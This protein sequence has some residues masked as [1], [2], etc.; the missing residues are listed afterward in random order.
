M[1]RRLA[2]AQL[3]LQARTRVSTVAGYAST[4]S[5]PPFV[6]SRCLRTVFTSSIGA[7]LSSSSLLVTARS[8]SV[9]GGVG[10]PVPVGHLGTS[11]HPLWQRTAGIEMWAYIEGQMRR[12]L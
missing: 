10:E 6:C 8:S 11:T 12:H 7:P 1:H 9:N 4:A 5:L 3:T 2:V